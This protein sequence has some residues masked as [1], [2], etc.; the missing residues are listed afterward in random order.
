MAEL[1]ESNIEAFN[2]AVAHGKT[3]L[4]LK[5]SE[6]TACERMMEGLVLLTR[7]EKAEADLTAARNEI[8]LLT[9]KEPQ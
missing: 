5:K 6:K 9:Y 4:A 7:A 8:A 2:A 3:K 1:A